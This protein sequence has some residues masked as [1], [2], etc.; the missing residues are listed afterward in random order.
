MLHNEILDVNALNDYEKVCNSCK[1]YIVLFA[2]FFIIS[3]CISS[4][5]MYFH[6][7]LKIDNVHIKF[8]PGT[9]NNNLINI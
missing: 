6:S 1:I 2:I 3:I 4:V 8:C 9:Q 5:F 7:Y